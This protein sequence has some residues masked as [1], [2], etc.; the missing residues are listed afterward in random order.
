[1]F[2]EMCHECNIR[3]VIAITLARG[4]VERITTIRKDF[5]SVPTK[6]A[7]RVDNETHQVQKIDARI[8]VLEHH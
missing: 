7:N 3:I 4:N 6:S 8:T 2:R 5:P 1:M